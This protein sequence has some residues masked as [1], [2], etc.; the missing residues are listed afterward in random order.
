MPFAQPE[1]G[2]PYDPD[3]RGREATARI[4]SA[5]N[6]PRIAGAGACDHLQVRPAMIDDG[7]LFPRELHE[8]AR[9]W[10]GVREPPLQG[11]RGAE[12]R[13][14]QARRRREAEGR[15]GHAAGLDLG[16]IGRADLRVRITERISREPVTTWADQHSAGF[17]DGA[18][19]R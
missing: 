2:G 12:A 9:G 8:R 18:L 4:N 10:A 5:R 14:T 19:T 15:D 3:A 17:C 1:A 13:Y 16:R 7:L 6:R 11:Q